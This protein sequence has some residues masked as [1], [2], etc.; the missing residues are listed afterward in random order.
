MTAYSVSFGV[1]T[2]S[3]CGERLD[4]A[5]LFTGQTLTGTGNADWAVT[6]AGSIA[7]S[8]TYKALKTYTKTAGQTY[9]LTTSPGGDTVDILM[10]AARS[11]IT[12]LAADTAASNQL[13][14]LLELGYS[15]SA[16]G[17]LV[18]GDTVIFL[19]RLIVL[20]HTGVPWPRA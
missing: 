6:S 1:K 9:S 18:L 11:D 7:P 3:G 14:T 20:I 5:G 10:V 15:A 16:N 13:K 12:V 17:R 4:W 8:G 2:R 19:D